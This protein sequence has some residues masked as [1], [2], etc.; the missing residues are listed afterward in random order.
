[1]AILAIFGE[2]ELF[3]P[4]NGIMKVSTYKPTLQP[5][6]D[7]ITNLSRS[8]FGQSIQVMPDIPGGKGK[9][10]LFAF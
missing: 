7:L 3:S 10:R 2:I 8:G 1:V 4:L 5:I 9:I 6:T